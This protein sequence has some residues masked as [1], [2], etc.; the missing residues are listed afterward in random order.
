M[1]ESIEKLQSEVDYYT[2][3]IEAEKTV[4]EDLE[5]QLEVYSEKL[6]EQRKDMG[7]INAPRENNYLVSALDRTRG[8]RALC[9]YVQMALQDKHCLARRWA[10]KSKC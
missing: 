6:L 10:S 8:G 7:G 1:Q 3:K 2:R 5:Y 9:T 4:A